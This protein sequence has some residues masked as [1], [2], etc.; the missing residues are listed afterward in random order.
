MLILAAAVFGLV[1]GSFTN[2]LIARVP[3]GEPW[4]RGSSRCP[5]CRHDLAWY[6]NVPIV[7]WLAL[8]RRCRHCGLPISA[9]YPT[10]ELLVA[11]MWVGIAAAFGA[12]LLALAFGYLACISVALVFIDLDVQ[13]LPDALVLPSY[14]IVAALLVADAAAS[15][16][17]FTLARGAAG[18]G[19]LGGFYG[20]LWFAYPSGLG[21]GDV[22]TAGLAGMV[23]G[24]L[25]W[26]G[27]AV[28]AISGPILGGLVVVIGLASHTL[29]RKSRVPY[30]PALLAGLWLGVF[31]GR[32]I[33]D[34]Y[35]ALFT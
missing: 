8:R 3:S 7:S 31:A 25:G 12:T 19:I 14:P 17:W 20:L 1:V 9:R 5:R 24:Y 16:E 10:V 15:G 18:V 23:L 2:V 33:G 13:R 11:L 30:G 21:R 4:I 29:T 26:S 22:T 6:D 32:A 34:W 27:L 28:G 35:V